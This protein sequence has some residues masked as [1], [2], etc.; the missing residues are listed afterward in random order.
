MTKLY[1]G[2]VEAPGPIEICFMWDSER[3]PI[4]EVR[5]EYMTWKEYFDVFGYEY[6]CEYMDTAWEH[7]IEWFPSRSMLWHKKEAGIG[8]R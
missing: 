8:G 2:W 7:R 5:G 1:V 4:I 3:F 6:G